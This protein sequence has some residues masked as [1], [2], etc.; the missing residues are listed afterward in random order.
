[1]HT[2]RLASFSG[3]G[4]LFLAAV[5]ACVAMEHGYACN[6]ATKHPGSEE[7]LALR[8]SLMGQPRGPVQVMYKLGDR[9]FRFDCTSGLLAT[10]T[11]PGCR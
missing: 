8:D 9:R 7:Y 3:L 6:D 4:R 11:T 2:P 10:M 5:T 1:M